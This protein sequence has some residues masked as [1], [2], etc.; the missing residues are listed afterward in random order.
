VEPWTI[1]LL[2]VALVGLVWFLRSIAQENPARLWVY[3]LYGHQF[4]PRTDVKYMTKRE[5]LASALSFLL[6]GLIFF[7]VHIGN[8]ILIKLFSDPRDPAAALVL[9][10]FLSAL[11]AGMGFI[12]AM[13]LA[14]RWAFRS[15]K[16]VPPE[17]GE[18]GDRPGR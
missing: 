10:M 9:I 14:V 13:Y 3:L 2:N 16:Y 4:G 17:R 6:V 7:S 8:G 1:L 15:R 12:G 5:L 11:F 18:G